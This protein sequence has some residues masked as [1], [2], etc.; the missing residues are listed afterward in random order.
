VPPFFIALLAAVF[1]AIFTWLILRG[2]SAGLTERLRSREEENLRLNSEVL[3]LRAET[4]RLSTLNTQLTTQ[5]A[6]ERDAQV[7]LTNEF[8]ALSA[9]ALKSNNTSF[10]EL[11]REAFAKLQ[12]S[13]ASDL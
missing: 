1:A 2:R 9:D 3:Q 12:Q 13:S 8:K 5:L 6:A 11:A 4:A 7:R 10:L